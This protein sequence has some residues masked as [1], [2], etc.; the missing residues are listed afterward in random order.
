[1]HINAIVLFIII[2]INISWLN[3]RKVNCKENY[4]LICYYANCKFSC[5]I[6][7]SISDISSDIYTDILSFISNDYCY[8]MY[9]ND[10]VNYQ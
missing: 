3:T 5:A 9:R 2:A 8:I 1:M 6:A 7:A 10:I 4:I